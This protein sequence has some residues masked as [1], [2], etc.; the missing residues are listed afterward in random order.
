MNT[1]VLYIEV[2]TD[3]ACLGNPGP[4]GWACIV[5]TRGESD[6]DI[7]VGGAASTTNNRMEL[8]AVLEALK[9]LP[10]GAMV[11]LSA[12]SEYVLKGLSE[13][14]DGWK[15]RGWRTASNK[16]VKNIDLWRELDVQRSRMTIECE[17]VEG[18]AGHYDNERCDQLARAEAMRFQQEN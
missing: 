15:R 8:T 7:Q 5:R 1:P 17:W 13:W 3:G 12:D 18:H 10:D 4:G 2:H 16:P 6:E 14:M 11:Q 9:S